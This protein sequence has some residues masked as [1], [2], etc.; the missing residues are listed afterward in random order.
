MPLTGV[1]IHHQ[2]ADANDILRVRV[3]VAMHT[4]LPREDPIHTKLEE[5]A[6]HGLGPSLE[7]VPIDA[8]LVAICDGW[9]VEADE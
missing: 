9:K 4:L 3:G 7:A 2:K 6:E 1:F 5:Q 8:L